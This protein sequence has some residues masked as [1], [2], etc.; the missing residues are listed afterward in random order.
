MLIEVCDLSADY[1]QYGS[2]DESSR[3]G[4]DCESSK[5]R[6]CCAHG[7]GNRSGDE[8]DGGDDGEE[9][10]QHYQFLWEEL[11][12]SLSVWQFSGV[13]LTRTGPRLLGQFLGRKEVEGTDSG[14]RLVGY[15]VVTR[16]AL[17]VEELVD[18]FEGE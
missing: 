8:H 13:S 15:R 17:Q 11:F 2:D 16:F 14:L 7:E 5:C 6:N 3:R 1:Q 12:C 4:G 18:F 9:Q 10:K